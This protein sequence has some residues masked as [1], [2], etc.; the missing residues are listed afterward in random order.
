MCKIGCIK[1]VLI[2]H[3][4][5][6]G[7]ESL[8]KADEPPITVAV[9]S[10][11]SAHTFLSLKCRTREK[12]E[13]RSEVTLPDLRFAHECSYC[14]APHLLLLHNGCKPYKRNKH[15]TCFSNNKLL[16]MTSGRY[17]I[18][19]TVFSTLYCPAYVN[20]VPLLDHK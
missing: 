8:T 5:D 7:M 1:E 17:V 3:H 6:A 10:N 2:C 13:E 12:L 18:H 11:F 19:I 14:T 9:R 15:T 20:N 4:S 16:L